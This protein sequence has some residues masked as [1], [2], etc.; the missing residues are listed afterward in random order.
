MI[1]GRMP[2]NMENQLPKQSNI[3]RMATDLT[4][5]VGLGVLTGSLEDPNLSQESLALET[6]PTE[7][8]DLTPAIE[9][10]NSVIATG[11]VAFTSRQ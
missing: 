2:S 3:D 5:K 11:Q 6:P 1:A 9:L 4:L 8:K 7:C 10:S